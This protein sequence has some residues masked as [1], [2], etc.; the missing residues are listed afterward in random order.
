MPR[1]LIAL[2]A[3]VA[4]AAPAAAQTQERKAAP[5][6]T[7]EQILDKFVEA[8]GGRKALEKHKTMS[9]KG[10]IEVVGAG[11]SGPME[12]VT[13]APDKVY[14]VVELTGFGVIRQGYD[15]SVGWSSDPLKGTQQLSGAE[16]ALLKREATFNDVEWRKTWKS[17]ELTGTQDV[18][19][20]PAYVVKLTPNPGEGGPVTNYYDAET[21][22]VVRS[23]MVLETAEVTAPVV[24]NFSDFRTVDG[25]KMAF[26]TEQKLPTASLR[27]K[28]TEV[29]FD[30]PVDDAKFSMPK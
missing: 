1:I 30:V 2:V 16:L 24:S 13:K 3:L 22:L 6:L 25:V 8:S 9:V 23:E 28:F 4:L 15:G 21:F 20:R 14:S 11:L 26:V 27:T 18:G 10:T 7:A 19:G 5:K 29:T 17:V 12:T